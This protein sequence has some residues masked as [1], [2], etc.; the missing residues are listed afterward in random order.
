ML[1][2]WWVQLWQE[3]SI[4]KW[5]I[6]GLI[7]CYGWKWIEVNLHEVTNQWDDIPLHYS[8]GVRVRHRGVADSASLEKCTVRKRG[9]ARLWVDEEGTWD[10]AYLFYICL[11]DLGKAYGPPDCSLGGTAGV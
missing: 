2:L 4:R 9:F 8:S 6:A 10:Y 11:V 7:P 5:K 1:L 3:L